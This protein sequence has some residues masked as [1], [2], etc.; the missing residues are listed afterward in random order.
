[1][2]KR[3]RRRA[4]EHRSQGEERRVAVAA[5]LE[6]ATAAPSAVSLEELRKLAQARAVVEAALDDLVEQ[7]VAAGF[8][9]AA[10]GE[11]LGVTRQ[12]ARQAF[13]RRRRLSPNTGHSDADAPEGVTA[14]DLGAG[15]PLG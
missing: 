10:I 11:Q 6:T 9:W 12:G 1:M 7:L 4:R 5:A 13:L 8:G 15:G 14:R 3:S 2:G